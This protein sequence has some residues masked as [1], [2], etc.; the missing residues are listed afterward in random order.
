MYHCILTL[1]REA[2]LLAKVD[3]IAI[4]IQQENG[5]KTHNRCLHLAVDYAGH[6][7]F[8]VSLLIG[9]QLRVFS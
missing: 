1:L 5:I 2:L 3:D 6:R 4:N 9:S 7:K 8:F